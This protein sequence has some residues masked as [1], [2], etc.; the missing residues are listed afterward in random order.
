MNYPFQS[1]K[2]NG[3]VTPE[4]IAYMNRTL[5]VL[6]KH[7]CS[8]YGIERPIIDFEAMV[9]ERRANMAKTFTATMKWHTDNRES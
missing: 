9:L 6:I 5:D 2:K 7:L 8:H 4:D 3:F 1:Q